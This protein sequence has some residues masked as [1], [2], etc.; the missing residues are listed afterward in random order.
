[1]GS[2]PVSESFSYRDTGLQAGGIEMIPVE[3]TGRRIS[4]VD[5]AVWK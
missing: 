3:T 5:K 2:I 4:G 1:M